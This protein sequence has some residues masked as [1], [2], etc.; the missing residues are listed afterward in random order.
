MNTPAESEP[1]S[2]EGSEPTEEEVA[3]IRAS[4]PAERAAVE[5]MVLKACSAR[6]QK[7]ARVVGAL[8]DE[9]ERSFPHLPF[10]FLQATM[11]KLEDIGGVE[12]AGD[13]WAMRSSE[14]RLTQGSGRS[15]GA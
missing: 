15:S 12:L 14:I 5:A 1:S 8:S 10:A 3:Q 13:V 2:P 4:A 9:F 7:V 6:W 11:E